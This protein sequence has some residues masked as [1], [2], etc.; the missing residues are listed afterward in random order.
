MTITLKAHKNTS[1]S[2]SS[3]SKQFASYSDEIINGF[4]IDWFQKRK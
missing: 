1:L 3:L 4:I 2:A